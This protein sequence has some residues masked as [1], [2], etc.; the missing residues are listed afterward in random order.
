MPILLTF[1]V[2]IWL[3]CAVISLFRELAFKPVDAPEI[4]LSIIFGV[5]FVIKDI[6]DDTKQAR[7]VQNRKAP[8][9][10]G[11]SFGDAFNQIKNGTGGMRL[12]QWSSDVRVCVQMPD[13]NSKMTA[14]YLYVQSRFGTVPFKETMI[15]LFSDRWE[16]VH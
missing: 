11:H 7:Y 4:V 10:D 9:T 12:P 15:E 14:P 16:V 6:Y 1:L 3:V 5:Y 13:A 8:V 2:T